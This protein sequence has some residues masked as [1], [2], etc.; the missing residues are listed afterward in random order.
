M[1]NIIDFA[2]LTVGN[3]A[4]KRIAQ[5]FTRAGAPVV[6]I[7]VD[8]KTQRSSG[9]SFRNLHLTFADSQKVTLSIKQS[10]D[11]WRT[12]I[13]GAVVPLKAQDD[14]K[15]AVAEL[16]KL[17]DAGR[18]K[19]QAK[20]ARVKAELPK[21]I[22]TAAPRMEVALQAKAADLDTQIVEAKATINAMREELGEPVLDSVTLDAARKNNQKGYAFYVVTGGKI[23][24]GWEF[25]E[26]AKEHKAENM[27]AKLKAG[28]KVVKKGGLKAMGLDPDANGDWLT[29]SALDSVNLDEARE[30]AALIIDGA[31]LDD[32]TLATE[33][34]RQ[35]LDVVETNYPISVSEG[36]ADQA[37]LQLQVAESIRTALDIL[38]VP[39]VLKTGQTG[40]RVS[41]LERTTGVGQDE[42][43]TSVDIPLLDWA[44]DRRDDDDEL[45]EEALDNADD[46]EYAANEDQ[47]SLF[48]ETDGALDAVDH[49]WHRRTMDRMKTLD[50]DALRYIYKDATEAAEAGEKI[51]NP[52]SGQYRDEAHYASMELKR[53]Q[54][55]V[56]DGSGK[57]AVLKLVASTNNGKLLL[58]NVPMELKP[59][60]KAMLDK[61][62]LKLATFLKS[63][64]SI[65][66]A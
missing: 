49:T 54:D 66:K 38:G 16:V 15:K 25:D 1:D 43:S 30:L 9:V 50:E 2:D 29:S 18:A 8:P 47:E 35:A 31:T 62:E 52:K 26:D 63:G 11:I 17:L 60:L 28:A 33:T 4:V 42:Q 10:G 46:E 37:E 65:V 23:E 55:L 61:K 32:A 59:V 19:H 12:L 40:N 6:S 39:E 56:K 41:T 53:R 21:G 51:D 48:D 57:R 3:K 45:E 58:A 20:M 22:R 36:N 44:A 27:P 13:N 7:D 24:S 14:Q 5:A 34:L 64:D